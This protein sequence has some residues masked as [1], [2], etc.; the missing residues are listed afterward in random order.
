MI[1]R[2]IVKDETNNTIG[3]ITDVMDKEVYRY[4]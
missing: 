4:E 3:L 1:I 2:A